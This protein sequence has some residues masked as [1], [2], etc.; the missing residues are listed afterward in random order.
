MIQTW[1]KKTQVDLDAAPGQHDAQTVAL[2]H[3]MPNLKSLRQI[4]EWSPDPMP[5]WRQ[6][7]N[8]KNLERLEVFQS[9]KTERSSQIYYEISSWRIWLPKLRSITVKESWSR[10]PSSGLDSVTPSEIFICSHIRQLTELNLPQ[11]SFR[12]SK[13][14]ESPRLDVVVHRETSALFPD[15]F[16][17]LPPDLELNIENFHLCK[18]AQTILLPLP[19]SSDYL[20][21]QIQAF[22][23]FEV[24][25]D[26]IWVDG[27]SLASYLLN[28]AYLGQSDSISSGTVASSIT[29]RH[30]YKTVKRV[31]PSRVLAGFV[32]MLALTNPRSLDCHLAMMDIAVLQDEYDLTDPRPVEIYHLCCAYFILVRAE[33]HTALPRFESMARFVASKGQDLFEIFHMLS[34]HYMAVFAPAVPLS[35]THPLIGHAV[36]SVLNGLDDLSMLHQDGLV[37]YLEHASSNIS[38]AVASPLCKIFVAALPESLPPLQSF[39][40]MSSRNRDAGIGAVH[41]ELGISNM[42]VS[43]RAQLI[44]QLFGELSDL[45]LAE[46]F[47]CVDDIPLLLKKSTVDNWFARCKMYAYAE[48]EGPDTVISRTFEPWWLLVE[49]FNS[50]TGRENNQY[51]EYCTQ[52]RLDRIVCEILQ[53]RIGEKF[54]EDLIRAALDKFPHLQ[55]SLIERTPSF[56]SLNEEECRVLRQVVANWQYCAGYAVEEDENV[57]DMDQ[58]NFDEAGYSSCEAVFSDVDELVAEFEF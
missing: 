20:L 30:L 58:M 14:C 25:L 17:F 49:A 50:V 43:D 46:L 5:I 28:A 8:M 13:R 38:P 27:M 44:Q 39:L 22:F 53:S 6:I 48:R 56:D 12:I 19:S 52:S 21:L 41:F 26:R 10:A 31:D 51:V 45:E 36:A 15:V 33:P 11:F 4:S 57:L 42:T 37:Q 40:R 9:A 55:H 29:A 16:N 34:I 47:R 7:R 2:L 35:I 1:T 18:S 24:T 32:K 54:A 23:K 3:M